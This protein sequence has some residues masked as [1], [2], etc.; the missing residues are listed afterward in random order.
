V[1]PTFRDI[2]KRERGIEEMKEGVCSF[3]R[4]GF[5]NFR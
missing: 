5:E 3:R 4:Q 2:A 1:F